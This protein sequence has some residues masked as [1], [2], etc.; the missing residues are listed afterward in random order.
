MFSTFGFQADFGLNLAKKASFE[1]AE[2]EAR[3]GGAA[4]RL[5]STAYIL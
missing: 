1:S 4:G 2:T 3:P 5:T